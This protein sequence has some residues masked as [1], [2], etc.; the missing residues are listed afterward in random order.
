MLSLA[1]SMLVLFALSFAFARLWPPFH[2]KPRHLANNLHKLWLLFAGLAIYA[3]FQGS[4]L[5]AL[6]LAFAPII[7]F[8]GWLLGLMSLSPKYCQCQCCRCNHDCRHHN[9]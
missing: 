7:A 5:L 4:V 2:L 6:G 1:V 8:G 3:A 9:R